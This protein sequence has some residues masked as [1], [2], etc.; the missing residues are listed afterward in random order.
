MKMG[1]VVVSSEG[2]MDIELETEKDGSSEVVRTRWESFLPRM[3][4]RVL[5]VE[6]DDSTRQIISALLRKCGYRVAAVPDGLAAWETLKCRPHSIDLVLT[7][8]ELPSISGFA[9]L[10]LVMEHDV[11]KNIPVIMMSSHDSISMVLKCMLKGAADF[12][13]KPVRRNELRNLWQHV[14][15][16]HSLLGGH[17]PQNLH[18]VYHKGGAI[19][20]NNIASSHSSDYA[21]SSQKNK[22]SEKS[23]CTSSPYLEAESAYVQNM[24]GLSQLKCRSASNTCSTDME[25]QNECA[26]LET[27]SLM[28]ESKTGGSTIGA[29]DELIV[30]EK[31]NRSGSEVAQCDD[32]LRLEEDYGCVK[33]MPQGE[34]EGPKNDRI[35]ADITYGIHGCN[36]ELIEPSSGAIDLIGTFD[37]HQEV[38]DKLSTPNDGIPDKLST[39]NDR[40]K[41]CEFSPHLELSLRKSFPS[42]SN[43]QGNDERHTL[44]HSAASAF[45]WYNNSKACPTPTSNSAELKDGS[46]KSDEILSNQLSENATGGFQP[47]CATS[48]NS[49]ENMTSLVMG[50]SEQA[51]V[52]FAGPHLGF[53]P[54]PG[55]RFDNIFAGYSH[56]FP[57]IFYTKSGL[58]PAWSPNSSHQKEHHRFPI[59]AS[60]HSNPDV[61][62]SEQVY[63]RTGEINHNSVDQTV[64]EQSKGR[65]LEQLRHGSPAGN[66][67]SNSGLCNGL[68]NNSSS[69][70]Y[71]RIDRN[72]SSA[73]AS[74]TGTVP[75]NLNGCTLFI[76]DR[77]N[78]ISARHSSQRDAA[79][80]KFRLKRKDRCY[81]K[82][83]RYQSRKSLAEQRPRVK[84]QFV[85]QVKNETKDANADGCP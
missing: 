32:A 6:A 12:L 25:K 67:S 68:A 75:Q 71:S 83:V 43:D 3:V 44:N 45:L 46:S 78:G 10:T 38:P 50:Q 8:V 69:G 72:S 63:G 80:T 24:Q 30:S 81:D 65:P 29:S 76:H 22:G 61:H 56:I 4:L 1:E 59:S 66:Q 55:V 52:A 62:D 19:S 21:A 57:S 54:V 64:C 41:K 36:D 31:L 15:R 79:L 2:G 70:T 84:G 85:R 13:I 73:K 48:S 39:L 23:S 60:V 33:T 74:G 42:T 11:C 49:R 77:F 37:N 5:L 53:I 27:E 17:V 58:Q 51:A 18:D 26:K 9:L 16:R 34:G 14:W 7:E 28:P 82:K 35:N 20:E 40:T 47:C